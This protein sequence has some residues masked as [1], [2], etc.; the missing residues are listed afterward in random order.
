MK[1]DILTLFPAMFTSPFAESII[2]RAVEK[3]LVKINIFDIRDYA[4][5]KHRQ[6]D[7]YPMGAGPGGF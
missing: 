5:G 4:E 1:I 7:D 2:K 6:V 3:T